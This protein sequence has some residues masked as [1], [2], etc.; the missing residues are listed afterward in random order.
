[1]HDLC[2]I[3]PN[4][5]VTIRVRV[6]FFV[7]NGNGDELLL[8]LRKN[9]CT[10]LQTVWGIWGWVGAKEMLDLMEKNN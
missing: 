9:T 1:M 10:M 5:E 8:K 4:T 2:C 7:A 6:F 3:S